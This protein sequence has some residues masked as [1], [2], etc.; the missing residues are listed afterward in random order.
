MVFFMPLPV[1][2]E[3]S[4]LDGLVGRYVTD[5]SIIE[6]LN[7]GP[8]PV[9][10]YSN[11]A[12]A[13]LITA[14][15]REREKCTLRL[16]QEIEK[17]QARHSFEVDSLKIELDS[18]RSKHEQLIQV[19]NREISELTAAALKRPGDYSVWWATGGFAT[20]IVTTLAIIMV[21]K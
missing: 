18:L 21:F 4:D 13:L 16:N 7:L 14:P 20:G 6:S 9:W 10:C 19:K 12:N 11:N 2:A 3:P 5:Q 17:I 15:E 8:E 1:T